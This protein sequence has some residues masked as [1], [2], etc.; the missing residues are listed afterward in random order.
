MEAN[1]I[2]IRIKEIN[3]TSF[4][5]RPLKLTSDQIQFGKNL[6]FGLGFGSKVNLEKEELGFSSSVKYII[7]DFENP[8][9]ELETEIIFEV[10]GLAKVV[11]SDKS[12]QFQINDDFLVT[13]FGIS[14][15]TIRG[16]LAA[17]TKGNPLSKFPLPVLNPKEILDQMNK[18]SD[19]KK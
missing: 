14:I 5:L 3:E 12:N 10:K 1:N 6:S 2:E 17:N 11:Q 7:E 15:G 4:I 19:A 9:I 16:M 18:Q 13:L 8:I